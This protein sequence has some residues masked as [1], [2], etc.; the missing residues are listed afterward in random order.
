MRES[1]NE[2]PPR[3]GGYRAWKV[4]SSSRLT[5]TPFFARRRTQC[6]SAGAKRANDDAW[7]SRHLNK[8]PPSLHSTWAYMV[9][10]HY[11]G[12]TGHKENAEPSPCP[13]AGVARRGCMGQS[14]GLLALP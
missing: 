8:L 10:W 9:G 13:T 14:T 2:A 11:P 5:S 12:Q 1:G 3:A 6:G 4:E 7:I